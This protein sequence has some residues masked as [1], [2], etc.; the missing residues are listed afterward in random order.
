[1]R[2]IEGR[3]VIGAMVLV[4]GVFVVLN[5]IFAGGPN[6]VRVLTSPSSG[7]AAAGATYPV[8]LL[9]AC[10]PAVDFDGSYW[11]PTG[12]WRLVTPTEPA[13]IRLVS[14]N[15]AVLHLRSGELFRLSRRGST[16][17]LGPC[18]SPSP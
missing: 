9:S 1:M 8:H 2:R 3:L 18:R 10:A 5:L 12:H 11:A 6:G 17:R 13:T 14:S 7:Q 15:R 4:A 16:I